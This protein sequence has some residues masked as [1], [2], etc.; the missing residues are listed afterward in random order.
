M[1]VLG[2]QRTGWEV[3]MMVQRAR[4]YEIPSFVR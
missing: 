1:P 3:E 2:Q 4:E